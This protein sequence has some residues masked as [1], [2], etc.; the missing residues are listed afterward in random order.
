MAKNRQRPTRSAF[1]RVRL[2]PEHLA[3]VQAH[4]DARSAKEGAPVTVSD[5]VRELLEGAVR[6]GMRDLRADAAR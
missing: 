3:A 4:A 5:I 2:S 1:L 6:K